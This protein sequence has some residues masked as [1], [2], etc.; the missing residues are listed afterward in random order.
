MAQQTHCALCCEVTVWCLCVVLWSVIHFQSSRCLLCLLAS[1]CGVCL[2]FAAGSATSYHVCLIAAAAAGKHAVDGS[3]V[4]RA[5]REAASNLRVK[6]GRKS[7]EE[8][9]E[10]AVHFQ[11]KSG[12]KIKYCNRPLSAIFGSI[13][14]SARD[15]TAESLG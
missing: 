15:M 7:L 2:V 1:L 3:G 10:N 14:L 6:L 4:A 5:T 11:N 13:Y 8:E 12:F 9:G